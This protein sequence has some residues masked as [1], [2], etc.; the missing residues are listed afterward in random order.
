MDTNPNRRH[1]EATPGLYRI[2]VSKGIGKLGGVRLS[3]CL[4]DEWTLSEEDNANVT[5]TVDEVRELA[6]SL[7]NYVDKSLD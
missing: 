4:C 5:L 3:V 6:Q 2:R 1:P 7:L